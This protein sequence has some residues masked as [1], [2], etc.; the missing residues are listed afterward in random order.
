MGMGGVD[1]LY[2]LTRLAHELIHGGVFSRELTNWSTR[3]GIGR[4]HT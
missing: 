2:G 1:A 4:R 3:V